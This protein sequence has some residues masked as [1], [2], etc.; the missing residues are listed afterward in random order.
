MEWLAA[1]IE[2]T[3]LGRSLRYYEHVLGFRRWFAWPDDDPGSAGVI[4]GNVRFILDLAPQGEGPR[5]TGVTFY[6]DVGALDL[7]A[8]H[9]EVAGRGA[10]VVQPPEDQPWGDRTF[11]VLYPDGYRITFARTV[12]V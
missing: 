9:A 7:D 2:V 4:R 6:V 12:G 5:G 3:D 11:T 10:R 8:Y 1:A